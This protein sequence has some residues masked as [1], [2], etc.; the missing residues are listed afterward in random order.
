M[1]TVTVSC[2]GR[3]G[4]GTVILQGLDAQSGIIQL[5]NK[6]PE[7]LAIGGLN[8]TGQVIQPDL[9]LQPGDAAER[10]IPPPGT[11]KII[12]VGAKFVTGTATLE[13]DVPWWS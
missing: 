7:A 8:A 12:V 1:Q 5:K 6:G 3:L 4:N 11:V 13:Y 2:P 10:W 9:F